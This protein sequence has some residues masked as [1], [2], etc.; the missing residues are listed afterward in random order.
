MPTIS[1]GK[2]GRRNGGDL[3]IINAHVA[4]NPTAHNMTGLLAALSALG[5]VVRMNPKPPPFS[6]HHFIFP[7]GLLIILHYLGA[8]DL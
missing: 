6:V 8:D 2:G 1:L 5:T 3:Q 4:N 7:F